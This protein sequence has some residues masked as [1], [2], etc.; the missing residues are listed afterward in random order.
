MSAGDFLDLARAGGTALALSLLLVFGTLWQGVLELGSSARRE[1]EYWKAYA[2]QMRTERDDYRRQAEERQS[3]V[4]Q[5][6]EL[7]SALREFR[8]D[9]FPRSP[10]RA[11]S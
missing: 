7:A 5:A 4:E 10:R 3:I 6:L 11:G 9:Q 2:E 1:R 8:H